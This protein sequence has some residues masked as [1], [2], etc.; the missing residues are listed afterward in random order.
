MI[1]NGGITALHV[2]MDCDEDASTPTYSEL[3]K[4]GTIYSMTMT[5]DLACP[6]YTYNAL[7]QFFAYYKYL[8]GSI[9]IAAGLFI[10]VF[11]R[12]L[13][14]PTIFIVADI[15]TCGIILVVCYSTF[16]SEDFNTWVS[17]TC[18]S[19]AI[20]IGCVVGFLATRL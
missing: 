7:V 15:V 3:N 14:T 12:K 11:G 5:S 19:L 6:V 13:F 4:N 2:S 1:T 16:L 8:W 9:F 18:I 10:A 17:W 20:L